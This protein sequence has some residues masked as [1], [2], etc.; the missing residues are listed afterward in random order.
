MSTS[1]Y[2]LDLKTEDL[3]I[4]YE[5]IP[6]FE[7]PIGKD[8]RSAAIQSKI[9][10]LDDVIAKCEEKIKEYDQEI[11]RLTSHADGLDYTV[12]VAS[13]I[14]TGIIDSLFVG[15][16]S[17]SEGNKWGQEKVDAFVKKTSKFFGYKGDDAS[18]AVAFLEKKFPIPADKATAFFGGGLQHHLRDFSHHPSLVGLFFSLLTQFTGKVYGTDTS[19]SFAATDIS[20]SGLIGD[21]VPTKILYGVVFWFFHL[22]SDMAG[23]SGSVAMGSSGTGLPGPILSLAKELSALPI[24]KHGE[25]SLSQWISKLFN[26]TLLAERNEAGKIVNPVKFDLRTELGTLQQ[27]GK[28]AIPVIIN[29]CIVRGFYFI[30]RLYGEIKEKD[31]RN[32]EDLK[33]IEWTKVVPAKNR[34]VIRMLTIATGTFTAFDVIDAAIRSAIKSGGINPAF[35]AGLVMRVNFVGVGRFAVALYSDVHMGFEK[36]GVEQDRRIEYNVLLH[37]LNAKVYY[38]QAQTWIAAEEAAKAIEELEKEADRSINLYVSSLQR[39][40]KCMNLIFTHI[41]KAIEKN[42]SLKKDLLDILED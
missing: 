23:S 20:D 30:R 28:Q 25:G 15:E 41:P 11:D 29:E 21:S 6:V 14:L 7:I 26:G 33:H 9:E 17:F 8:S 18:G 40:E 36:R 32:F 13:G 34:T 16:F 22:V 27:L 24:F 19:G 10:S 37:N 2:S 38:K 4:G 1:L 39:I 35:W 5:V 12:A 42:K 31:V 3:E